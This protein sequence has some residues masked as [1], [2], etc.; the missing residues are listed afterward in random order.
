VVLTATEAQRHRGF[1]IKNLAVRKGYLPP[2]E[3]SAIQS[4]GRA[5][6]PD[7]ELFRFCLFSASLCLC[8]KLIEPD[9]PTPAFNPNRPAN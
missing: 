1:K 6:L 8:G 3:S 2:L 9:L 7:H 5:R 4:A